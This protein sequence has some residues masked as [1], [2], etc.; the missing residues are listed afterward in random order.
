MKRFLSLFFFFLPFSLSGTP[1]SLYWTN[2]ITDV[3]PTG[4]VNFDVDNYFT[5]F[6]HDGEFFPP[7][8]GAEFGIFSW[9]N[10]SAEAGVDYNGGTSS[11]WLFNG[12]IGIQ[13]GKFTPKA[14]A[15]SIGVFDVGTSGSTNFNV[16]DLVAGK[17]LPDGSRVFIGGF[18]GSRTLGRNRAGFMVGFLKGFCET[19]D[20]EGTKF[21][22]FVFLADYASG[23]NAIGGGGAGI[24]YFFT[25]RIYVITGPVAF[26]D[27][28][29]NGK[30][31]W[32][33][34]VN[35]LIPFCKKNN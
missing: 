33:V 15:F 6:M 9:G 8:V 20:C 35:M 18:V 2:C 31:K 7:S 21:N 3:V 4:M 34:Q 5:I 12:K 14:P 29:F 25:P 13:E 32:T 11:P 28:H 10:W 24:S 23:K 30:W 19:K 1:T 22:R 17:T 26:N 16:F 27:A